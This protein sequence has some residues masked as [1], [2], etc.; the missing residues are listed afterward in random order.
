VR[1]LAT[2]DFDVPSTIRIHAEV[3][4][5]AGDGPQVSNRP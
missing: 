3:N 1:D 4:V 5:M 2:I